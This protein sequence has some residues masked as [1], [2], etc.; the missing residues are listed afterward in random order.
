[1]DTS[2]DYYAVLGVDPSAS[3]STIKDA[4]TSLVQEHHP[5]M[6]GDAATFMQVQAAFEVLGD[7]S[8]REQYDSARQSEFL[9][10]ADQAPGWGEAA[11]ASSGQTQASRPKTG[12]TWVPPHLREQP[13]GAPPP[14]GDAPPQDAQQRPGR[15]QAPVQPVAPVQAPTS[16][17]RLAVKEQPKLKPK[18]SPLFQWGIP[19]AVVATMIILSFIA[20]TA[21]PSVWGIVGLAVGLVGVSIGMIVDWVKAQ[22]VSESV[23]GTGVG[24]VSAVAMV[25]VGVVFGPP[26]L[27]AAGAAAAVA[28]IWM[29]DSVRYK[30]ITTRHTPLST[31]KKNNVYG[32]PGRYATELTQRVVEQ[33]VADLITPLFSLASFRAYHG[34]WVPAD[35]Q[36]KRE[37]QALM[38]K[39]G[40]EVVPQSHIDHAVTAGDKVALIVSVMWPA[41]RYEVDGYGN[42]LLNGQHSQFDMEPWDRDLARWKHALGRGV[43]VRLILAV[44]TD[45]PVTSQFK[46]AELVHVDDLVDVLG[47]W[48]VDDQENLNRE[49]NSRVAEHMQSA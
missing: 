46:G 33:D 34:L 26:A 14:Q 20:V 15:P 41:G 44:H 31:L 2:V 16:S 21:A 49:L 38:T 5:D 6:G 47:S 19:T 30:Y 32:R 17:W 42:V 22:S 4:W 23:I 8:K 39:F 28:T 1:M 10:S 18:R 24:L 7:D 12:K 9:Q 29:G 13:Q 25:A 48:M 45:G 37:R 40:A 43:K 11:P 27:I 3:K 35:R 36:D